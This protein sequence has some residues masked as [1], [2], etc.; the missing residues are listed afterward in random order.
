VHGGVDL[1]VVRKRARRVE[2]VTEGRAQ[3][4]VVGVEDLRAA[5]IRSDGV[6][7][8]AVVPPD[9][10]PADVHMKGS[11]IECV[12]EDDRDV[13]GWRWC[14]SWRGGGRWPGGRR[15]SRAVER[16]GRGRWSGRLLGWTRRRSVRSRRTRT[17]GLDRGWS[18]GVRG[19]RIR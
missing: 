2:G 15:W 16:R 17:W 9:H 7:P 6:C 10:R 14:R 3:H 8:V 4:H 11:R 12:R 5:D 13:V 19:G 18:G 1:A